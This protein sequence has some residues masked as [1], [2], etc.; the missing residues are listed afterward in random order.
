[1]RNFGT[2]IASVALLGFCMAG[3]VL[4]APACGGP[5]KPVN[6]PDGGTTGTAVTDNKGGQVGVIDSAGTSGL[7][8]SAKSTYDAG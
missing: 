1:M 6:Y 8:G 7:E 5:D 3:A 2:R 4:V